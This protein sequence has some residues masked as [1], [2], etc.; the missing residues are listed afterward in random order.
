MV[1]DEKSSLRVLIKRVICGYSKLTLR[2][3]EP[4]SERKRADN[5]AVYT[6]DLSQACY[7]GHN[8]KIRWLHEGTFKDY[9]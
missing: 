1:A 5:I 7:P 9:I 8:Y 3:H 2:F 6:H 4:R